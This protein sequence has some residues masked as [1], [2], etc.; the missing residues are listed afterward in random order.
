M[1]SFTKINS[2]NKLNITYVEFYLGAFKLTGMKKN[3]NGLNNKE[4]CVFGWISLYMNPSVLK[5]LN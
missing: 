5:L 3:L 1:P 4:P 2:F